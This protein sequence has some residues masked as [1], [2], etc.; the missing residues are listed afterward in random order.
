M[1][2]FVDRIIQRGLSLRDVLASSDLYLRLAL[3]NACLC[4]L[5]THLLFLIFFACTQ[6]WSLLLV[7]VGSVGCY[8]LC[9]LLTLKKRYAL[10]GSIL[11]MEIVL[12]TLIACL[13][14]GSGD[15]L[16]LC[17]FLDLMVQL[18][19]PYRSI[20]FRAILTCL[21]LPYLI[22]LLFLNERIQPLVD[23]GRAHVYLSVVLVACT[24]VAICIGGLLLPRVQSSINYRIRRQIAELQNEAYLDPLTHLHNRRYADIVFKK[25][26]EFNDGGNWYAALL[27]ID[28]FKVINDVY[29]HLAGDLVLKTLS[30]VVQQKL[31]VSDFAFRWGGEEFLLLV[32]GSAPE[33]T[34]HI[35]E[36][37]RQAMEDTE[38]LFEQHPIRFTVTI[39]A[40]AFDIRDPLSSINHCDQKMYMGKRGGKNRVVF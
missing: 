24:F 15:Y 11:S 7:N 32:K 23:L 25:L 12:Y 34:A 16:L 27:D 2:K 17:M 1:F 31:R 36:R 3:Q 30:D 14:T 38:V 37:I 6:V 33:E 28:D 40:D 8:A 13:V 21:F 22:F 29:G 9:L 19:I 26:L 39:G 18:M 10:A 20:R 4:A 5:V 35:L